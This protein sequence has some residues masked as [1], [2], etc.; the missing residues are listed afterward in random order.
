MLIGRP[1]AKSFRDSFAESARLN[2]NDRKTIAANP[3][4]ASNS[5]QSD[6]MFQ[7]D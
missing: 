6:H 3:G 5:W 1:I 4:D 7:L 2:L